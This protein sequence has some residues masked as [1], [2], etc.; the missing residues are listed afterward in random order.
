MINEENKTDM[1]DM[2]RSIQH[3]DLMEQPPGYGVMMKV[4]AIEAK[5][6][7]KPYLSCSF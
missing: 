2:W 4:T 3:P 7:G 5:V 6:V 1:S